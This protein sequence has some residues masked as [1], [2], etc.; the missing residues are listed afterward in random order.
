M[1]EQQDAVNAS[2]ARLK[3]IAESLAL[4][5]VERDAVFAT[6]D[7]A[8]LS[9]KALKPAEQATLKV[10]ALELQLAQAKADA[11]AKREAFGAAQLATWAAEAD[12]LHRWHG[13]SGF[14]AAHEPTLTEIE[15]LAEQSRALRAKA[16]RLVDALPIEQFE[17]FNADLHAV[18]P[19]AA[20][21]G[22]PLEYATAVN[23][24]RLL[25]SRLPP[26]VSPARLEK[27]AKEEADLEF[28][29]LV[30]RGI[31]SKT[32][33]TQ[34]PTRWFDILRAEARE[35]YARGTIDQA[36][37]GEVER[38]LER[39]QTTVRTMAENF[40]QLPR[41]VGT[42]DQN[43]KWAADE[44]EPRDLLKRADRHALHFRM[45]RA[46]LVALLVNGYP[47]AD[48]APEIRAVV[49]A[50]TDANGLSP[51]DQADIAKA[52]ELVSNAG[53][54]RPSPFCFEVQS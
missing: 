54:F 30:P 33:A 11:E 8:D 46:R 36:K 20:R 21:G 53:R 2:E 6:Y 52:R 39:L 29:G 26:E 45:K 37:L 40:R 19:A 7:H 10:Q 5:K 16:Q 13:A 25:K 12:E 43:L 4:A 3:A 27:L 38:R 14:V 47:A 31:D 22:R 28:E 24:L 1:H 50:L 32:W 42:V 41:I 17:Q 15:K 34:D 35:R 49:L 51:K 9:A 44:L 18:S 23:V 48:L